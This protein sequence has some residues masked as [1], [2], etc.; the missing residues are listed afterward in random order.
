MN[1]KK[2]LGL[3]AL[4]WAASASAQT[5][6]AASLADLSLEQLS[7]IVVSTV[8]GREAPLARAPAS[9]YVISNEDIRRSGATSLPEAL[10]LAPNL[11]IARADA[12]QWAISSRGFN[13]VL[14]NKMLVLIDGRTVYSPLFSGTF[15]EAQDVM[16]EDVERIEV[17][18]GPGATLWGANAVN[19]V[20]NVI[21]R[22]ARDTQG[23]L[24]S[25]EAGTTQRDGAVRYGGKLQDGHY[26]V[27]AKGVRRDTTSNAAGTPIGDAA[28]FA[29][30]GF[31]V[32]WGRGGDGFTLQ[33]DGYQS[34]IDQ[35]PSSRDISGFNLLARWTRR[36]DGGSSLKLQGYYDGTRRD[37]PGSIRERLDT[38][39]FELQ[40]A[41]AR[42]G[43]HD[44][45]WGFGLRQY[46]D[47]VE[48]L[49]AGFAFRPADRNLY[50]NH[51]FVQDEIALAETLS[52]TLG[53]KVETNSYT[54]A[55]WL[56]SARL[57]WQVAPAHLLWGA[58][59]R[60]VR[61]PAR[62]DREFFQPAAG[63]PF[64]LAGGPQFESEVADVFEVGYRAQPT[65]RLSFSATVFHHDY[66]RLRTLAPAAGGATFVNDLEGR[67]AGFEAWGTWRAADWLRLQAGFTRQD[68]ALRLRPG[69]VDLQPPSITGNDPDNWWKLRASLDLGPKHELDVMVR[70]Y[71]PL[72]NPAVPEYTALDA[73]LGWRATRSLEVALIGQN[74]TDKRHPEWGFAPGRPEF[75]R[76]VFLKLRVT[77]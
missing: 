48:N 16:L 51:L 30:A 15:W 67:T 52:L 4:A 19:G 60:T 12:N 59:S 42:S 77:L 41:L 6:R 27:Y 56:P 76:A 54:G 72:P 32:D 21:T 55:E 47:H 45:L 44:I 75:E 31:R 25:V 11:Q 70:H 66:D 13:N 3:L 26:R 73:R 28:E 5:Q 22:G 35:L 68:I 20:I 9:I 23:G 46:R 65:P 62:I 18:S 39:D 37:Q 38:Y 24:A 40:H 61:A 8:S 74:L 69:S 14:A 57:G 49:S 33:G 7:G 17:I 34:E 64:L 1:K 10:R 2:A 71:D 43:R 53:A 36:L 29:Q 58:A 63:P 50:R